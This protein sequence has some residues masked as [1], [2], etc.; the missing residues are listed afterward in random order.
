MNHLEVFARTTTRLNKVSA[1]SLGFPHDF[2]AVEPVRYDI[3]L[4]LEV[5]G[6][7]PATN[8]PFRFEVTGETGKLTLDGGACRE[9]S[10][11]V[12]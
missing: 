11:Q 10:S 7:R 12:D 2:F 1:V 9:A 3:P 6:G 8:T 4:S 5:A